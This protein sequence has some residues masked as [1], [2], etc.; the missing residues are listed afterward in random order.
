MKS[1][2]G[3]LLLFKSGSHK[4][5]SPQILLSLEFP[6][7]PRVSGAPWGAHLANTRPVILNGGAPRGSLAKSGD[8]FSCHKG[9]GGRAVLL[10]SSDQGCCSTSCNV[11]CT[12]HNK[13][14]SA[15]NVNSAQ[16]ENC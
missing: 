14:L 15:L 16:A 9:V 4:L 2:D 12:L 8:V 7:P 5:T 1:T 13:E 11:Q 6:R 10:T 3:L